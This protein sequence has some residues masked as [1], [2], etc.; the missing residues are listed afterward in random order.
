MK[1]AALTGMF[2]GRSALRV[3]YTKKT[4]FVCFQLHNISKSFKSRSFQQTIEFCRESCSI[5]IC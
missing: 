3:I 2:I 1:Y 4:D 5:G